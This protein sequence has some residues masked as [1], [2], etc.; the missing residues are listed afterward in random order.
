MVASIN[1]SKSADA[2]RARINISENIRNA[3]KETVEHTAQALDNYIESNNTSLNITV[4]Q[5][6]NTVIVKVISET[7]GKVIRE[8]ALRKHLDLSV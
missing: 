7:D 4:D 6:T 2:N 5:R 3:T 1:V 8:I